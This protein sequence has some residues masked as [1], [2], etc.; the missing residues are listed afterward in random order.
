MFRRTYVKHSCG[1]YIHFQTSFN[2]YQ[3]NDDKIEDLTMIS[4]KRM[5]CSQML[6][7]SVGIL[8]WLYFKK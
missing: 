7:T 1:F 2:I 5:I 6:P 4:V 3:S 8:S